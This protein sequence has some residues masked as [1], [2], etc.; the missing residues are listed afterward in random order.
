[1]ASKYPRDRVSDVRATIFTLAKWLVFYPASVLLILFALLVP[2][3]VVALQ[4][5]LA[6]VAGAFVSGVAALAALTM[7]LVVLVACG[8]WLIL[9]A[10][11]ISLAAML[12]EVLDWLRGA[13]ML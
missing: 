1:M 2:L 7:S 4:K 12:P 3:T 13:G 6:S 9:Q 10:D 5:V 11:W 8:A